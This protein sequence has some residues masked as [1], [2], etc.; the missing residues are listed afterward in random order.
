MRLLHSGGYYYHYIACL[1]LLI[2]NKRF[3]EMERNIFK[4]L[5]Y[6]NVIQNMTELVKGIE[7]LELVSPPD[8]ATF[9]V[10]KWLEFTGKVE[11]FI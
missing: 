6:T 11:Q 7:Q 5:I 10:I 9:N 2:L 4:S 8:K 3:S 1:I